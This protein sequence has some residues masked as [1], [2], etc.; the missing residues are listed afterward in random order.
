M[1]VFTSFQGTSCVAVLF[2]CSDSSGSSGGFA[3]GGGVTSDAVASVGDEVASDAA[4][5]HHE[6]VHIAG[7]EC[8]ERDVVGLRLHADI[9]VDGFFVVLGTE[10][11]DVHGEG[12]ADDDIGVR[13]HGQVV[14]FL[15]KQ[16]RCGG[17]LL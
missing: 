11:M 13:V 17:L 3:H 15:M 7:D 14:G 16:S 8:A 4:T 5:G 1:I 9:V 10:G 2:F 6:A 12:G